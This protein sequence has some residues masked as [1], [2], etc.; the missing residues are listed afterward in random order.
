MTIVPGAALTTVQII[1]G[2]AA[3]AKNALDLSKASADHDLKA[4]VNE[5]YNSVFDVKGRVLELDGEVRDLKAQIALKHEIEGPDKQGYFHFKSKPDKPL[6]PKCYQSVP[7][8]IAHMGPREERGSY[9]ARICPVCGFYHGES[10]VSM[11]RARN[12]PNSNWS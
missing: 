2:L 3:S 1:S 8:N 9:L 7:S 4:A 12:Y 11:P 10:E 5:L 6:C